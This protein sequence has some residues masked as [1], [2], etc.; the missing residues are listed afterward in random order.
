MWTGGGGGGGV[1]GTGGGSAE[2]QR[3]WYVYV[4][5]TESTSHDF[6]TYMAWHYYLTVLNA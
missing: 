5:H 2:A 4:A 1:V 3:I 6:S